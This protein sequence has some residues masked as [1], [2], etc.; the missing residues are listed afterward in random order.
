MMR[1]AAFAPS[2]GSRGD[3]ANDTVSD[4]TDAFSLDANETQDTDRDGMGDNA[5][6]CDVIPNVNQ[7]D[8]D[9]EGD[10]CDADDDGDGLMKLWNADT[11]HN[12]RYE[13]N[14]SGYREFV[15]GTVNVLGCGGQA[16]VD[17]CNGYEPSVN[18]SLEAYGEADG[19]RV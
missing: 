18:I 14:G 19:G 12:V 3:D 1:M 17:L 2:F 9:T 10:A 4:A 11:L 5:D 15:A 13:L 6:N 16:G 7:T 8:G